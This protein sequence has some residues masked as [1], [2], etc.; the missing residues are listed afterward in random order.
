MLISFWASIFG[1]RLFFW[2]RL[3]G[4][5]KLLNPKKCYPIFL[6]YFILLAIVASLAVFVVWVILYWYEAKYIFQVFSDRP[7]VD[8]SKTITN[9]PFFISLIVLQAIIFVYFM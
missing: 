7:G 6:S 8:F 4:M 9:Y 2:W 3:R 1:S 5:T